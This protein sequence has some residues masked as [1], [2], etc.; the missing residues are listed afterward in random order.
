ME[1]GKLLALRHK[2]NSCGRLRVIRGVF[3]CLLAGQLLLGPTATLAATYRWTDDQGQTVYS[4]IPPDDGRPYRKVGAPPPPPDP[5]GARR[6]LENL[7]QGLADR[8]EDKQR[9]QEEQQQAA[10][11]RTETEKNCETA[12]Q[13]VST[14]ESGGRRLIRMPDGSVKRLTPEERE[15]KLEEARRYL[16]N[17]CR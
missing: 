5:E 6:D 2:V 16:Q 3:A 8:R 1:Q 11:Q 9:S 4:Q 13:N 12:R 10:E 7:R 14:L 15:A 17:N